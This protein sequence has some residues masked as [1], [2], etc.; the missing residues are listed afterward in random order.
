ML[1]TEIESNIQTL[2]H[3]LFNR[4]TKKMCI[5]DSGNTLP[6]IEFRGTKITFYCQKS[7]LCAT[8]CV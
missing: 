1:H 7:Y 3:S 2:Y 5:R 4:D 6:P 8:R